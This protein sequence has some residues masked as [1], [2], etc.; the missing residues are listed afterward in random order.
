MYSSRIDYTDGNTCLCHFGGG[1]NSTLVGCLQVV[2]ICG[3]PSP[4][5]DRFKINVAG[6]G[7]LWFVKT[8]RALF[9]R[10]AITFRDSSTCLLI[11]WLMGPDPNPTN[12]VKTASGCLVRDYHYCSTVPEAAG[13]MNRQSGEWGGTLC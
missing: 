11:C 6:A 5:V 4:N 7:G 8:F 12:Q 13:K 10:V 9:T 3:A 1:L 2:Q